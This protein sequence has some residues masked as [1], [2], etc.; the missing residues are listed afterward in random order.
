V[1]AGGAIVLKKRSSA[2]PP[3]PIVET[4][5]ATTVPVQAPTPGPAPVLPANNA[6]A[7]ESATG[8]D[9]EAAQQKP[10]GIDSASRPLASQAENKPA[11]VERAEPTH[12]QLET[13][14]LAATLRAEQE[15]NRSL[16]LR[17]AELEKSLARTSVGAVQT[18]PE[19]IAAVTHAPVARGSLHS[20]EA[21]TRLAKKLSA[22]VKRTQAKRKQRH[23][24]ERNKTDGRVSPD[25]IA[26]YHVSAVRN[27]VAWIETPMGL[28]A[29]R[30]GDL[31]D[32]V[33]AVSVVDEDHG[34]VVAGG[35]SIR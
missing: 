35:A 16:E 6:P 8:A 26:Q 28:T 18:H 24:V 33:G 20:S 9:L 2:Q 23:D 3:V 34:R 14:Q 1:A 31:L 19:N 21:K 4:P 11:V 7:V 12:P 32:G 17:L 13:S 27:G 22:Q 29:V 5:P 15:K 25:V 30:V 10:S